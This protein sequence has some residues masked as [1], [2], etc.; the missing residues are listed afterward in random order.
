MS[1]ELVTL[2][3]TTVVEKPE[4]RLYYDEKGYVITYTTEKLPGSYIV[5]DPLTF[6]EARPDVCVI[7]GQIIRKNF[8]TVVNKLVPSDIGQSCLFED[9]SI[10]S[11]T[12]VT[13]NWSLTTREYRID[14]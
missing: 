14:S 11:I 2:W 10:I 5:V 6:A 4:F 8:F 13:K 9:V 12:G 7:D 3:E 1:E